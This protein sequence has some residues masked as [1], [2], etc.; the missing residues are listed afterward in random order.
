MKKEEFLSSKQAIEIFPRPPYNFNATVYKPSH[1]SSSDNYYEKNKYWITMLWEGKKLGLKLEDK[2]SINKPKIKVTIFSKQR[3]NKGFL[4]SIKPEIEY[5]FNT[6]SDISEFIK[7]FKNDTILKKVLKKW[8]GM[9]PVCAN[10]LYESLIILFVLQ[11]A[12]VR[13]TVQMLENL[14]KK[15]GEKVRFDNKELSTF[16]LPQK[17]ADSSEE[18]LRA[19]KLGYRAKMI[20][21]LSKQFANKEIDEF[22]LRKMPKEQAKKEILK[23]YGAGP[24]TAWYVLFEDFYHYDAFEHVSP[25]EQKI[26]SKLLFNKKLVPARKILKFVDHKWGKWKM[27]ASHYIWEDIFWQRKNKKIDWLEKEIRL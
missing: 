12:T 9:K 10:S 1:Y 6:N 17:I 26:Y 19:L 2:G 25:W 21:R 27:L 22:K 15:Y 14:F 13:R 3:L 7:K 16:W 4:K 23:I 11:N 5:R 20:L 24:A 18:E 8:K